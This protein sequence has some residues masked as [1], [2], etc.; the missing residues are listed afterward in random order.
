M[1]RKSPEQVNFEK[2]R[3]KSDTE[4]IKNG[5]EI[6]VDEQGDSHLETTSKQKWEANREKEYS[7]FDSKHTKEEIKEYLTRG[8]LEIRNRGMKEGV[9][10]LGYA[11]ELAQSFKVSDDYIS[12]PEIHDLV[13][14]QFIEYLKRGVTDE[15]GWDSRHLRD[16]LFFK[17]EMT[18]QAKELAIKIL[19]KWLGRGRNS[20]RAYAQMP[21]AYSVLQQEFKITREDFLNVKDNEELLELFENNFRK[22]YLSP[23]EIHYLR[24]DN[25]VMLE[26]LF[27]DIRMAQSTLRLTEEQIQGLVKRTITELQKKQTS[28][29]MN[30]IKSL[31]NIYNIS[32]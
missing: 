9:S 23:S 30:A 25:P 6:I 8:S 13:Q 24:E 14:K 12:S 10:D 18:E 31:K 21:S 4:L 2:S 20:S 1:S 28:Y 17:V 15:L 3:A 29:V 32:D 19:A 11:R 27:A 7:I 22:T 16:Y 26:Q 5:A